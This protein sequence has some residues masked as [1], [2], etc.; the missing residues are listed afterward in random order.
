MERTTID[1]L[2]LWDINLHLQDSEWEPSG[3]SIIIVDNTLIMGND[4]NLLKSVKD[5]L[6]SK[7]SM[8]DLGTYLDKFLKRF[9]MDQDKKCFL[10]V[11]KGK[12]LSL[13]QCPVSASDKEAMSN[14]PYDSAIDSIMYAMLST[15]PDVAMA[16]SLMRCFQNN[17]GMDHWTAV[18]NI[19][20]YLKRT[21][22]MVLVYGGCEEELGVKG[23][24]DASLDTDPDDLMSQNGYVFFMNG[25]VMK[26]RSGN[27]STVA[28]ST[29]QSE[30]IVVPD[31]AN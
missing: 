14:I 11:L 12:P 26:W 4:V 31:V 6:N 30:Y 17:R 25:G 18:K 9:G 15:R 23:Y 8:K 1:P 20:K 10:P 16:L 13:T 28:Q 5:Y 3:I 22:N 21:R 27:H 29:M 19:L 7:F 2:Y 24:V